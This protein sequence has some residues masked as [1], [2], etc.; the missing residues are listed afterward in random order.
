MRG[1]Q[2]IFFAG[3][4]DRNLSVHDTLMLSG[5]VA[6]SS[7]LWKIPPSV[8]TLG[9]LLHGKFFVSAIANSWGKECA[10]ELCRDNPNL[11]YACGLLWRIVYCFACAATMMLLFVYVRATQDQFN[12]EVEGAICARFGS[13]GALELGAIFRAFGMPRNGEENQDAV[14]VDIS[15]RLSCTADGSLCLTGCRNFS[16][17]V[18]GPELAVALLNKFPS[19]RVLK[20]DY[21]TPG[22]NLQGLRHIRKVRC[23]AVQMESGNALQLG[24]SVEEFAI[25]DGVVGKIDLS[26]C[27]NLKEITIIKANKWGSIPLHLNDVILP[28]AFSK[29]FGGVAATLRYRGFTAE[30]WEALQRQWQQ[31]HGSTGEIS[32]PIGDPYACLGIQDRPGLTLAEVKKAH[33]AL[34][35]EWHPDKRPSD[36]VVAATAKFQAIQEAYEEICRRKQ[37][38]KFARKS[39]QK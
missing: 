29:K 9:V 34:A 18:K 19:V 38:D 5:A 3:Q 39:P 16:C 10:V 30:E 37:W 11:E 17:T 2:K 24:S 1:L 31:R 13:F 22:M 20:F 32:T 12:R 33:K 36:H 14:P 25:V 28:E 4:L 35:M 15:V 7:D 26:Q 8:S 27:E 23:N 21:Q 6:V